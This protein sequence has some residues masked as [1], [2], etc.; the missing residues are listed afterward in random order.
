MDGKVVVVSGAARGMGRSHAVTLAREGAAIV[1]FDICEPLK[2]V[3]TPGATEADL[4]ETRR[5][6]EAHGQRCLTAKVDARDLNALRELADRAEKEFGRVDVLVINHGLWHVAP[7]SWDLDEEGWN[8]TIDIMLTGSWKVAKAFIPKIIV[9]ERGGAIVFTT[10]ANESTVQPGAADYCAAKAGVGHL[11]RVLAWELGK[12]RIRVNSIKPGTTA[13][14]LVLEGGTADR[15][16]AL[17][18]EYM[19]ESKFILP[20]EIQ[21]P[22]SISN[23]ILWLVSDEAEFVTGI[24]LPVDA[25]TA[26]Y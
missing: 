26:V 19:G 18:P 10:S 15:A 3:L 4:D 21:P 12:H 5:L 6:V 25:G 23:A 1:A 22:E 20:I 11:A 9:G 17:H 8:E 7:T 16:I 14:P 2:T 13:T 24:S